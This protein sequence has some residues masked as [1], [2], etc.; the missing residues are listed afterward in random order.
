MNKPAKCATTCSDEKGRRTV[1]DVLGD[2]GYRVYPVGRLD[3]DTEGLLILT[4]DGDFTKRVTHPSSHVQKTYQAAVKE[5]IES[6][7]VKELSGQSD[8][9]TLLSENNIEIVIHEGKNRQVRN[10][11]ES[12]SLT[13][14][15]LKRVAIGRLTLGNLK[16]GEVKKVSLAFL[17]KLL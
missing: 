13:V 3:W 5:R 4:N 6:H 12:I 16:S 17:N 1:L 9:V 8:K 15:K 10:M 2:V 7:H 11:L 14:T